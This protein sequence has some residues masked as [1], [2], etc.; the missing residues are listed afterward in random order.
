MKCI[1]ISIFLTLFL[2]NSQ[3][4]TTASE[5][6][7]NKGIY[8]LYQGKVKWSEPGSATIFEKTLTWKMEIIEII[9]RKG[10]T[11]AQLKGHPLDLVWYEDGKKRG[12]YL[13]INHDKKLYLLAGERAF[14]GISR[15]KDPDDNLAGLLNSSALFF[16][17]PLAVHDRY[18]DPELL[19]REDIFYC[20]FV[21][22]KS[23]SNLDIKGISSEEL[24][25]NYRITYRTFPDHQFIDIVPEVGIAR[26]IYGHHGSV[27]EVDVKL[28][29]F[30]NPVV[31]LDGDN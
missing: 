21:E 13:I 1:V 24:F 27:S 14:K 19:S 26:Y 16:K 29:E 18:G 11:A 20:W 22:E 5:F 9:K 3:K 12:T 28:V 10:I 31:E 25:I 15:L 8:W 7:L 30:Y 6:P 2:T 23:E 17:L 4:Q